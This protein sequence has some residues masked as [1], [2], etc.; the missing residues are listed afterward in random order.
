MRDVFGH[1]AKFGNTEDQDNK[2]G[3]ICPIRAAGLGEA[4]QIAH[5]AATATH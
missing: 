3:K 5:R 4:Q 1:A 2:K